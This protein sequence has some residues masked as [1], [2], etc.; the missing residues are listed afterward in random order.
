MKHK[1]V[2]IKGSSVVGEDKVEQAIAEVVSQGEWRLMSLATGGM[3]Q[4]RASDI[5]LV[6][7]VFEREEKS[8]Y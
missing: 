1:V 5:F 3:P 8:S 6:Y 2:C 4:E 7:L